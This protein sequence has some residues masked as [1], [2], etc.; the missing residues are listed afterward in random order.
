MPIAVLKRSAAE[1]PFD[2][3]LNDEHSMMNGINLSQT[4]S[5]IVSA[6]I[7]A[8]GDALQTGSNLEARSAPVKVSNAEFVDLVIDTGD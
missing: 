6:K 7:S 2:F 3:V 8:T 1:L 4:E 5:V